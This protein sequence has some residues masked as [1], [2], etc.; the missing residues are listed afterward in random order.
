MRFLVDE[1]VGVVVAC[2]LRSLD[3]EVFSIY[4]DARGLDDDSILD[5]AF[6]EGWIL[7]TGDKDFGEKVYREKRSHR[8]IVLL[9]LDDARSSNKI[10]ALKRLLVEYSQN[11]ENNYVVVTDKQIRFSRA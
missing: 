7:I 3:Y 1:N 11:L 2:W 10:D 6:T 4:E 5:K 8:G 9:R